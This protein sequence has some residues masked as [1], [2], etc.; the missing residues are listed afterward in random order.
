VEIF[1][2]PKPEAFPR[3]SLVHSSWCLQACKFHLELYHPASSSGSGLEIA[4]EPLKQTAE[5]IFRFSRS[6]CDKNLGW[7]WPTAAPPKQ[8]YKQ[9]I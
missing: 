3:L 5:V 4:G 8:K 9:V 2:S 6:L 1:H 7:A